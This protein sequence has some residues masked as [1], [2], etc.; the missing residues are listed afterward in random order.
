MLP[1]GKRKTK[2]DGD[3]GR[4]SVLNKTLELS[5]VLDISFEHLYS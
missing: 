1:P 3:D 2:I 5:L 4:I